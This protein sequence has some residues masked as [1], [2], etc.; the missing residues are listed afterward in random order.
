SALKGTTGTR[1][2]GQTR[3]LARVSNPDGLIIV[4]ATQ[5]LTTAS[6][7]DTS[8]SPFAAALLQHLPTPG[9]DVKNVL[10]DVANDVVTRTKGKQ[11]PEVSVSLFDSFV[12]N[13]GTGA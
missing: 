13:P 3:G 2:V 4:Y 6:D 12:L 11:R 5:F 1:G 7:G 8:N 10:F 9:E